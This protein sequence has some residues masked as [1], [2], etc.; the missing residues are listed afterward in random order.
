MNS[1][2]NV[3]LALIGIAFIVFIIIFMSKRNGQSNSSNSG[4]T[5]IN[6][7]DQSSHTGGTIVDVLSGNQTAAGDSFLGMFGGNK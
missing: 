4:N 2:N 6:Y 3:S 1:N 7:N 5:H